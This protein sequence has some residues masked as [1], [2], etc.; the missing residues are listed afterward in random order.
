LNVH[1]ILPGRRFL[2]VGAGNIGLIVAYQL[3]QAGA[4]V[5]A[6]IDAA[7]RIGGYQVHAS[8]LR[9]AGVPILLRH[10]IVKATGRNRVNSAVTAAVDDRFRPVPDTEA[11]WKVD[12]VCLAVGLKPSVELLAQGGCRL[13]YS[14][15]LGGE[16]PWHDERLETSLPGVFVA[17]DASGI[18][19]ASTAMLEG[20]LAGLAAAEK[21]LGVSDERTASR[22]EIRFELDSLRAG[23][24]GMR[25]RRGLA[26]LGENVP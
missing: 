8:K 19:E 7:P 12:T 6:V 26:S 11:T 22:T 10:T 23:P 5:A 17:G 3:I 13:V 1:G 4:E 15:D 24:F 21:L 16:V 14:P 20:R 9:R 25:T 2:M 18:E